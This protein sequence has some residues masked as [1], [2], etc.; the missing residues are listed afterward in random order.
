MF[1]MR[2]QTGHRFIVS[3][4]FFSEFR[5]Q[6]TRV[7]QLV[8][9]VPSLVI[10]ELVQQHAAQAQDAQRKLQEEFKAT[11]DEVNGKKVRHK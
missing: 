9:R 2:T 4:F 5:Q 10:N 6:L 3:L 11:V 7:E 1:S 8:A